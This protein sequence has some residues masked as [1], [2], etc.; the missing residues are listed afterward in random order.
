MTVDIRFYELIAH[1]WRGGKYGYYWTP[2]DEDGAKYTYWLTVDLLN[3]PIVPKM[4]RDWDAYFGVNPSNIRR[5]QHE[6][7]RNTDVTIANCLYCEYDCM[8]DANKAEWLASTQVPK[9]KP[10]CVTDSGGGLHCYLWLSE[11]QVL[12]T[13]EKHQR[14]ADLQ[15]AYVQWMSGDSSVNDLARVLRIPGTFNR[16]SKYAPNFPEVKIVL[17]EP[18]RQYKLADIERLL[19]PYIDNRA[20][21]KAHTHTPSTG[22]V[23]LSDR[24]L[25]EVLFKSKNGGLY[26][27]LWDGDTTTTAGGDH[28]KADQM[29]CNGLAWLTGRDIARMDSLFRQSGLMRDKW[30]DRKEYRE[31]TLENAANSA[32]TV[33][34]PPTIDQ[35]AIDAANAA[36][37]SNG[38]GSNGSQ[39][40]T[41]GANGASGA[42]PTAQPTS[43]GAHKAPNNPTSA[44]YIKS[45]HRLGYYFRLNDLDNQVEVN[46]RPL[47]DVVGAD[48]RTEMRDL[49]YKG[50]HIGA[51]ED[52]YL[53][54]A[55][56]N[57]Y[58][59]IK[60]YLKSLSWNGDDHIRLLSRYFEDKHGLVTYD[61]G[62]TERVFY[63]W[64]KRWLVGAVAK[65]F[66]SSSV[67]KAQNAVLVLEGSQNLGK[68]TFASWLCSGIPEYFIEQSIDPDNKEHERRLAGKWIWEIGELGSTTRKAD[69]EALK[70]FLSQTTVTFRTPYAKKD[71]TKPALASFIGTVNNEGG[72]LQDST[73]TRRFM[74]V[75]LLQLNHGYVEDLDIDQ[76]WA[77]AFD[78]YRRGESW[79]LLPEEVQMREELNGDYKVEDAYEGWV[80]RYFEIDMARADTKT[81]GWFTTTQEIVSELKK[82]GVTGDTH[83][84]TMRLPATMKE[85]G[86]EKG[87]LY[88]RTGPHGYWG[89][90]IKP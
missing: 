54:H 60:D 20:A 46:S 25:L 62:S 10:A 6:R 84:I 59:P 53:S 90:K 79:R 51:M 37:G 15:W 23:S 73:G 8:D 38:A 19:Q 77:Q 28:S 36:V 82:Q 34:T 31:R 24:E 80:R 87:R 78:L 43:G 47:D 2:S 85:L 50:Q 58:H 9:Y 17:W 18:T 16:K 64:L 69:R 22:G 71:I 27:D 45:L 89:V 48:I 49:G 14:F 3:A 40:H 65:V 39:P 41:N 56:K 21:I 83:A 68:S 76:V 1:L 30:A 66:E 5:S 88:K 70:K 42:A 7:A 61:N 55:G 75:G 11:T 86:V 72:F 26:Q 13:P 63:V 12:D 29:L 4:F 67:L 74:T 35:D 81:P 33:Y 52:A 32:Q 44:D 57:R